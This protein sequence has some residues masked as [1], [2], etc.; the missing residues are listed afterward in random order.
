MNT[1]ML[2]MARYETATIPLEDI[3]EE[4]FNVTSKRESDAKARSHDYP[5]PVFKLG[6]Q[7]SPWMV[8]IKDLAAH[9]DKVQQEQ[10]EIWKKM[11]DAA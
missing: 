11:N 4:Y 10:K 7:R 6:G 8:H 9:I 5:I 3:R 2:L 1:L